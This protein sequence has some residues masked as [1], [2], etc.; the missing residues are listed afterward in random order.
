MFAEQIEADAEVI[1]QGKPCGVRFGVRGPFRFLLLKCLAN[2]AIAL[3]IVRAAVARERLWITSW[4]MAK[5]KETPPGYL[6]MWWG[7][8]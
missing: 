8:G 4:A 7:R 1:E 3:F 5:R 6:G 2:A